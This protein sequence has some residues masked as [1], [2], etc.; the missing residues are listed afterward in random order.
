MCC[1]WMMLLENLHCKEVIMF[2]GLYEFQCGLV[3]L[4][5]DFHGAHWKSGCLYVE[6]ELLSIHL[7]SLINY[8]SDSL[9]RGSVMTGFHCSVQSPELCCLS[10]LCVTLHSLFDCA[11][12][13]LCNADAA[14]RG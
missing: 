9:P 6:L 4:C 8:V 12:S 14:A 11:P 3:L 13:L 2:Y 1:A 5:T 7:I 10:A